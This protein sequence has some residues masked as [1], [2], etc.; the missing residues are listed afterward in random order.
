VGLHL[1]SNVLTG[2]LPAVWGLNGNLDGIHNV[3][4]VGNNLT[5]AVPSS[6][7]VTP[8]GLLRFPALKQ[9]ILKPGAHAWL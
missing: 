1:D 5:G 8:N 2:T 9:F 4:L 3:S 6:W 7:G